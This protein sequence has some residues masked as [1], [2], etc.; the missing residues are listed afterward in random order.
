MSL[1]T[2]VDSVITK[3]NNR[4]NCACL[5]QVI[6]DNVIWNKDG[7]MKLKKREWSDINNEVE[8][9]LH[10]VINNFILEMGKLMKIKNEEF[11]SSIQD[12]KQ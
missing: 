4:D 9:E 5:Q 6:E 7:T 1:K 12:L 8:S 11:R 3:E 10:K 2:L